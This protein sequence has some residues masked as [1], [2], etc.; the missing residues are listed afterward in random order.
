MSERKSPTTHQEELTREIV[1]VLRMG[2]GFQAALHELH[3]KLE[4]PAVLEEEERLR[5]AAAY[6]GTATTLRARAA[7]LP[8]GSDEGAEYERRAARY[9]AR[10][11]VK[12]SGEAMPRELR[13]PKERLEVVSVLR[14]GLVQVLAQLADVDAADLEFFEAALVD[15]R[16]L[17]PPRVGPAGEQFAL[18]RS[19]LV[20]ALGRLGASMDNT[21][22]MHLLPFAI[23]TAD[24]ADGVV[25]T[26]VAGAPGPQPRI[27]FSE[28]QTGT[29]S[30]TVS[31]SDGAAG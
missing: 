14:D 31:P 20:G 12:R 17:L 8:R 30:P 16:N 1:G 4:L 22:D 23:P 29:A 11:R 9:E 2:A 18:V 26:L 27:V 28:S 7:K 19:I 10:A 24:S 6:E 15:E 13:T 3:A 25:T 21:G 5:L